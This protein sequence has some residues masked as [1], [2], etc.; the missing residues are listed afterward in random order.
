MAARVG[1]C[2]SPALVAAQL[3]RVREV[4]GQEVW[5]RTGR[6]QLASAFLASLIVGKWVGMGEAE[7]CATGMWA[8]TASSGAGVGLGSNGAQ[9]QGLGQWDE[10]VLEIVGGSREEGRRVRGWLG[11]VDV[12]GGGRKLGNVSRYWVERYGFEPGAHT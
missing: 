5:G 10:G 2:A 4:W 9:M 1:L 11:D 7:A 6:V 12:S 8:H 3:L